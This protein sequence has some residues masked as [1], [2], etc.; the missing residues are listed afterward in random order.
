[1]G[2]PYFFP[3]FSV[4]P[5]MVA[6]K[7]T[8]IISGTP[9]TTGTFLITVIV[10]DNGAPVMNRVITGK[11]VITETAPA[12]SPIISSGGGGGSASWLWPSLLGLL[13]LRCNRS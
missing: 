6:N 11:A 12:A 13:G 3:Y 1:M 5:G 7:E 9:T 10:S 8:G 2:V 4:P